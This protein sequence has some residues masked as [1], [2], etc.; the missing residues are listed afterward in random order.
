[1]P[2]MDI[3]DCPE[4]SGPSSEGTLFNAKYGDPGYPSIGAPPRIMSAEQ[5]DRERDA[6]ARRYEVRVAAE[7]AAIAA[8][9]SALEAAS[10]ADRLIREAGEIAAKV[11]A[12]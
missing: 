3:D 1:M 12:R 11:S 6:D 5:R 10:T 2:M 8:G 7:R 9:Q 4:A